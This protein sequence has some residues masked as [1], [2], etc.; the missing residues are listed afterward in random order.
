MQAG[1]GSRGPQSA[2]GSAAHVRGGGLHAEHLLHAGHLRVRLERLSQGRSSSV[3]A[4]PDDMRQVT[5]R[6]TGRGGAR[7]A[8]QYGCQYARHCCPYPHKPMLPLAEDMM[9]RKPRLRVCRL[10]TL[11]EA[12]RLHESV[13]LQGG[14]ASLPQPKSQRWAVQF[15]ARHSKV[16]PANRPRPTEM[17]VSVSAC[18]LRLSMMPIALPSRCGW[19]VKTTCRLRSNVVYVALK[20]SLATAAGESAG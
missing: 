17:P 14:F 18:S 4:S 20:A 10:Q 11:N 5:T 2:V 7:E 8:K 9:A 16:G 19:P 6:L 3:A 15:T 1:R 12:L 13:L